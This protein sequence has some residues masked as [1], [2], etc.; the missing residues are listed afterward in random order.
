M[1]KYNL[2]LKENEELIVDVDDLMEK[3]LKS[4][5]EAIKG[6]KEKEITIFDNWVKVYKLL[7][8][9]II[10]GLEIA[11]VYKFNNYATIIQLTFRGKTEY[12]L[13]NL[14]PKNMTVSCMNVKENSVRSYVVR[15]LLIPDTVE[16]A[17]SFAKSPLPQEGVNSVADTIN[18]LKH[19]GDKYD[20][21]DKIQIN[22]KGFKKYN[23]KKEQ[24]KQETKTNKGQPKQEEVKQTESIIYNNTNKE[25]SAID[26]VMSSISSDGRFNV[27]NLI[28]NL[29]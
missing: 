16:E 2:N 14:N 28:A 27:S 8:Y 5:K 12:D 1:K 15:R 3:E 20:V 21:T 10:E 18:E 7:N 19:Q 22:E 4:F 29:R 26:A 11:K 13:L 6:L 25:Y 9:D 23:D 17:L 24:P